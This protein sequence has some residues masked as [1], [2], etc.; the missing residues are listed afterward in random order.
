MSRAANVCDKV[1]QLEKT[2][3]QLH[4]DK[5]NAEKEDSAKHSNSNKYGLKI[6]L[7]ED[8]ENTVDLVYDD[9]DEEPEEKMYRDGTD[10]AVKM[11]KEE[12]E[13]QCLRQEERAREIEERAKLEAILDA[14]FEVVWVK[15]LAKKKRQYE[16]SISAK[17]IV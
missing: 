10:W 13:R 12:T 1:L 3:V 15:Y 11:D 7:E 9:E 8:E 6:E 2:S 16:G 17:I 4:K 14:E 5:D